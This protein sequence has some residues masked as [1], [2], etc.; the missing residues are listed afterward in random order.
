M[1]QT[2]TACEQGGRLAVSLPF[3]VVLKIFSNEENYEGL[4]VAICTVGTF[5]NWCFLSS[6]PVGLWN[7]N[8]ITV[9][10][11]LK[12]KWQS[13]KKS[14]KV[15]IQATPHENTF[16]MLFA[17]RNLKLC[18]PGRSQITLTIQTYQSLRKHQEKLWRCQRWSQLW[19]TRCIMEKQ[20]GLKSERHKG[21]NCQL[22]RLMYV[23]LCACT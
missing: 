6:A 21:E 12:Q 11:H 2:N 3:P 7:W 9:R 4:W 19:H 23:G 15:S 10:D 13:E 18:K 20:D 16:Y 14:E 17:S 1:S 8:L 5:R 22:N